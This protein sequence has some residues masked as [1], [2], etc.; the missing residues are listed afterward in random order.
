MGRHQARS[1][2]RKHEVSFEEA[3]TVFADPL[4]QVF[5][6]PDHSADEPRFLLPGVSYARR[7]VIVVHMERGEVGKA[8]AH[9]RTS[10]NLLASRDRKADRALRMWP[11]E[12]AVGS[13]AG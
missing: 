8:P 1:N 4:A 12:S 3:A 9:A 11:V 6:H 2:R 13:T 10:R 5:D 7:E